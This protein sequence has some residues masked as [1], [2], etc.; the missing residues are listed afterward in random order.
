M[1]TF[2]EIPVNT[3]FEFEGSV[4][5]KHEAEGYWNARCGTWCGQF[6]DKEMVTPSNY[7]PPKGLQNALGM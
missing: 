2:A 6:E 7:Q 1:K 4:W 3:Y 5:L